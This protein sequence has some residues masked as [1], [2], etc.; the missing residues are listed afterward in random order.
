LRGSAIQIAFANEDDRIVNNIA[1]PIW[2]RAGAAA[3]FD[4]RD[5][6]PLENGGSLTYSYTN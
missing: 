5:R 4:Y 1:C 3:M 2:P 6:L